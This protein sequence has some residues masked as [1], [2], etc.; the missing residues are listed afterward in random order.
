MKTLMRACLLVAPLALLACATEVEITE[1]DLE[2][3]RAELAET[4][5]AFAAAA[6]AAEDAELIASYWADEAVIIPPDSPEVRGKAAILEFVRESMALPGFSVTW[7]P[8]EVQIGPSGLVGFTTGPNRFTVPDADGN[9][10]TV[11]GTYV[12]VWQKQADGSWKCVVDIWNH[13]P[14]A[15][16]GQG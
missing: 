16:G 13:R 11:D 12:T 8:V 5:L 7:E 9:I 15:D 10:M 14:P 2:A 6:S 4:D 1:V 3:A